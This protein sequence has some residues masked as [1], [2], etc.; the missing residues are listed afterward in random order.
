MH[1][2]AII[3]TYF[4][5]TLYSVTNT[6]FFLLSKLSSKEVKKQ[7]ILKILYINGLFYPFGCITAKVKEHTLNV[8]NL[9]RTIFTPEEDEL[10]G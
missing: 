1:V 6:F 9:L 3:S 2:L 7:L 4:F 8:S 5:I 10:T